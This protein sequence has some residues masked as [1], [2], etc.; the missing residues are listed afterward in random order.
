VVLNNIH[1]TG[2]RRFRTVL[3]GDPVK[4]AVES[5]SVAV[6]ETSN[7][8]SGGLSRPIRGSLR[9]AALIPCHRILRVVYI[10]H[11][12]PQKKSPREAG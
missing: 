4:P 5:V 10:S 1:E 3:L 6:D 12:S 9:T 2:K 8:L 11:P 7:G